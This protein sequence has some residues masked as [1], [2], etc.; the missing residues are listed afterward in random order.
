MR[1][2]SLASLGLH[3]T[4]VTDTG[5]QRLCSV[6]DLEYLGLFFAQ[7]VTERSVTQIARMKKLRLLGI[8]MSGMCPD[9]RANETSQRLS[10]LLPTCKVDWGD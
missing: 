4:K 2:P 6:Y 10:R 1:L 5:I 7:R 3:R 9:A 8:G